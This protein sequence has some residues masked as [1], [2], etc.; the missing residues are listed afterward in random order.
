MEKLIFAQEN[1]RDLNFVDK[2]FGVSQKAQEMTKL[3]GADNII[4][5]TIGSLLDD[6]GK[7][8]VF[9]SVAKA[10]QNLE[11]SDFANYAPI[12]GTPEFIDVIQK[13]AFGNHKPDMF[14]FAGATPG[15]AGSI[16]NAIVNYS[17]IG[18]KI[19][20]SDWYWAAYKTLAEESYRKLDTY[21]LLDEHGKY[22]LEAME[23]KV[24]E[25]IAVQNSLLIMINSPAHNPTGFSLT[26]E[27]WQ[28]VIDMANK[29]AT[30]EKRI[31][32]FIDAAYIDFTED[33][34]AARAFLK[35]FK[36]ISD[37]VIGLFS[38]SASKAFTAYGLRCGAL[39]C[40][41]NREEVAIEFKNLMTFSSRGTWS[42]GTRAAQQLLVNLYNDKELKASVDAE[43]D[44]S[45]E[46]LLGRGRAF[47][48]AAEECGLEIVPYYSGFFAS[49]P[50]DDSD[51]VGAILQEEGIFLVPLAKGLRVALSSA[52]EAQCRV[53]PAAIKRAMD[54]F[55]N[56]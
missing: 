7:L 11:P 30:D 5:A 51:A 50:C 53:I 56:R 55:Y 49:V 43:R 9:D 40:M 6:N 16:R 3:K 28:A 8:I 25:L 41:T 12:N 46:M 24:K 32:I 44:A 4:N 47:E 17:N 29:Y 54:K 39:I 38:Y 35:L 26:D 13:Y 10:I 21:P 31:A 42:N 23:E 27:D 33:P 45:R 1:G 37:N 18:E 2:I 52:N 15:G 22:N 36:G 20:T 34:D 14:T 19:L 48:E